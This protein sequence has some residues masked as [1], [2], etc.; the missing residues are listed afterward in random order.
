MCV[1]VKMIVEKDLSCSF[2]DFKKDLLQVSE[3]ERERERKEGIDIGSLP[4]SA[5]NSSMLLATATHSLH[6]LSFP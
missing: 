6:L 3:E 4:L 5:I 1:A 2:E